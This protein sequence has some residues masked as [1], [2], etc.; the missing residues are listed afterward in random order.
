MMI[1]FLAGLQDVPK[2]LYEAVEIDGGS[3][4]HR[5]I[6]VTLPMMTPT[7]LFNLM[8][9]IVASLQTFVQPFIMTEG[10]PNNGSLFFVFYI[11]R[12]AF[13][14]SQMGYASALAWALFVIIGTLS[15]LVFRTSNRWVFYHGGDD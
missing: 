15:Y 4:W 5:L 1:I 7:I 8:I 9:S 6:H 11:Y 12:T 10:G 13:Q 2:H 14:H 3:A